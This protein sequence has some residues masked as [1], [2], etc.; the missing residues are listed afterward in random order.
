MIE[1]SEP[2]SIRKMHGVSDSSIFKLTKFEADTFIVYAARTELLKGD[3]ELVLVVVVA[4]VDVVVDP[5]VV[6]VVVVDL[7]LCTCL[8]VVEVY[9]LHDFRNLLANCF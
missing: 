9:V 1:I 6:V 8:F 5:V 3:S 7:V 2:Q 4:V